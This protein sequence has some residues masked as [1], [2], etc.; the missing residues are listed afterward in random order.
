[1]VWIGKRYPPSPNRPSFSSSRVVC[2]LG[3]FGSFPRPQ[4]CAVGIGLQSSLPVVLSWSRWHADCFG[5]LANWLRS[6]N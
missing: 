2:G 1:M 3:S 6:D 4:T 5:H